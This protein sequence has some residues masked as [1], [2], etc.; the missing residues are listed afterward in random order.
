MRLEIHIP[1]NAIQDVSEYCRIELK[2]T[3]QAR[4]QLIVDDFVTNA[5]S[6]VE[7]R[8][9]IQKGIRELQDLVRGIVLF[10][11]RGV[12]NADK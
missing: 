8:R 5:L 11:R 12:F 1:D 7:Q 4:I 2:D 6:H 10:D 3:L 9:E